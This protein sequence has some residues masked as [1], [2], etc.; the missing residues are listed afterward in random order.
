MKILWAAITGLALAAAAQ[1]AAAATAGGYSA[2]A[3]GALVG[4][5]ST[6]LSSHNKAVLAKLLDGRTAGASSKATINVKADAVICHAGDVDIA[7]FGCEL[8]FGAK[9]VDLT[10]RHANELFA[11]LG[12]AGVQSE[13]AAGTI[14]EALHAMSCVIDPAAIAKKDGSGATCNFDPGPP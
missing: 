3:L 7:S 1:S 6:T 9:K 13:G 11:T 8:T 5:Y 12:E 10:G 14:Y 4:S 2:L